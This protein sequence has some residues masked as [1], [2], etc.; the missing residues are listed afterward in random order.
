MVNGLCIS[1]C[2]QCINMHTIA[3]DNDGPGLDLI[4]VPGVAFDKNNNRIGH[5]KG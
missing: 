5:G 2:L 4:L 3:L 1:S